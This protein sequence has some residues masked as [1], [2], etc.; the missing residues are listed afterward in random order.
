MLFYLKPTLA[1]HTKANKKNNTGMI[2]ITSASGPNTA[3]APGSLLSNI[4]SIKR[5]DFINC[6]L[7]I[8]YST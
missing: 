4:V 1:C 8:L 2:G 6:Y 7:N 3:K 5:K